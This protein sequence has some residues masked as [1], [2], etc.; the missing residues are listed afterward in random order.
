LQKIAVY[1]YKKEHKNMKFSKFTIKHYRCFQDMQTLKFAQ[2]N[3]DK[4]GSGITFI[5]GENNSGKTT[6]IE[7]LFFRDQQKIR[8]SERQKEGDSEF[9]LYDSDNSVQRKLKVIRKSSYT[10]I[11]DPKINDSELFEIVPSRRHWHSAA[12]GMMQIE[13]VTKATIKETPRV[14]QAN[15]PIAA[16]LKS[17]EADDMKYKSFIEFVREVLPE[18]SSFSIGFEE[19]E[20]IEYVT[21]EGVRH[22]SDFLGDGVISILRIL[23][24][25]F[26]KTNRPLVIDEPELSLH[27]LAQKRLFKLVAKMATERQII[28]STHSPYFVSWEYIKNGAILNKIAKHKDLKS[29]IHQ[30][31]DYSTYEKLIKRANWQQPFLMDIVAKEIFF[32]DNIL[33][34]E[35]QED[36]GLLRQEND[37]TESVNLFGYG[38]RGKDAFVFAL[39]LAKDLGIKK[40]GVLIDNGCSESEIKNDLDSKFPDYK[41][42]QWN[43]EDIRDK[44]PREI[45]KK[46]GYFDAEGKKKE[47]DELDDYYEKIDMLNQY[48]EN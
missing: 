20:Y 12:S 10:L 36:V 22:K 46:V 19:N 14:A 26:N 25:L 29:E 2:P 30:L 39:Q 24:H 41:I 11:E 23:C 34:V 27:P 21:N 3:K 13:A 18:F 6:L 38:I 47:E 8:G 40:A 17:I 4:P 31:Q 1:K 9:Q 43:K 37:I 32:H 15:T 33:F 48:F 28:I 44:E 5:V 7:G 35:G 45:K 42:V 16:A